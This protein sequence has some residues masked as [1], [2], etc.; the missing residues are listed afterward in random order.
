MSEDTDPVAVRPISGPGPRSTALGDDRA[1]AVFFGLGSG[2][3]VLGGLVA[4]VTGPLSLAHGSWL[5][6]YLV[7]VCGAA[8]CALGL[9]QQRL[10]A[11]PVHPRTVRTQLTCW[12]VGNAAVIAGT[13]T[14]V[15]AVVDV[16]GVLVVIPL[17]LTIRAVRK[18]PRRLPAL[19][20]SA[21]MAV[22]IVS[23]PI[24]LVLAHLRHG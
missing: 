21:V 20:Y 16:G 3:V 1:A 7:L 18:S 24:G 22:L 4:A 13:L 12:N 23:I 15:P 2:F 8:Q 17:L 5:A 11:L 19:G 6:A 9:A 10:A 14:A